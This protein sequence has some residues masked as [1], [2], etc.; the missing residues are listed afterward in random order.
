LKYE[1]LKKVAIIRGY[2]HLVQLCSDFSEWYNNWRPHE[3]LGSDTPAMVFQ[4]KSVPLVPKTAKNVPAD[5]EIKSF[6]ETKV[7]AYKIKK[8][9]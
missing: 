7:T 1:W 2:R 6:K 9:A 8:A 5:L 4:N 3:F